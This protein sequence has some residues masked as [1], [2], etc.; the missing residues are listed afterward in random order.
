MPQRSLSIHEK[1]ALGK[2]DAAS[3]LLYSHPSVRVYTFQPPTDALKTLDRTKKTLPDADYPI[4][5]IEL[6]PW[7]SRTETLSAHGKLIIEKVQGSV[8]FLKCGGVIHTIMRNS[9]CWCVDGEA[10]FVLRV[11][12]LKYQRLEFPAAEPEE[13]GKVA[14]FKEVV[15]KILKFEKTPCPFIRAFQVDLPDDAITPRRR[16]TWKR[17]ESS[18]A[19][20]DTDSPTVR[21]KNTRTMSMRG[22]PPSAFPSRSMTY[23][24]ADRPRTASTPTVHG[25]FSFPDVRTESPTNYNSGED[26]TDSERHESGSEHP[27]SS[28]HSE[29][30][31]SDK[32]TH[33]VPI[34]RS[35]LNR[36]QRVS[37]DQESP[38]LRRSPEAKPRPSAMGPRRSSGVGDHIKLFESYKDE[39]RGSKARDSA[40]SPATPQKAP[41]NSSSTAE[42]AHPVE[43]VRTKARLEP[44]Q[45]RSELQKQQTQDVSPKETVQVEDEQRVE[46][47]EAY[48]TEDELFHRLKHEIQN[49]DE[50]EDELYQRLQIE[51]RNGIKHHPLRPEI[52]GIHSQEQTDKHDRDVTIGP[53]HAPNGDDSATRSQSLAPILTDTN[54]ALHPA[55]EPAS[56]GHQ[57][58]PAELHKVELQQP[59]DVIPEDIELHVTGPGKPH[60]ASTIE[61]AEINPNIEL[62]ENLQKSHTND[63][64][65]SIMSTDSFH[66]LLSDDESEPLNAYPEGLLQTRPFSHRRELSE[67]TVTAATMAYE[68]SLSPKDELPEPDMSGTPGAFGDTTELRQRLRHRRSLSPLPPAS[69][70]RSQSPSRQRSPIP[71][72][73]LQKAANLAVVKPIEVVMFVMHVLA[74]IAGG[75]TMNDL[76]S[77]ALF[78]RPGGPR[79]TAS[80]TFEQ[81]I[82]SK[83]K[84]NISSDS[85]DEDNEEDDYGMPVRGRRRSSPVKASIVSGSRAKR[86]DDAASL[87][88]VD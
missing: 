20:P 1:A 15:S 19:T 64:V 45:V 28:Q 33:K 56:G 14:E 21:T 85:I 2:D 16:G 68:R 36:M 76:T 48:E 9:Q 42:V 43:L 55:S 62:D 6:L 22:M 87:E 29:A 86:E 24:D 27:E 8:Q 46:H 84:A 37:S 66:T 79:R 58:G 61:L 73:L 54:Q 11:G 12:R 60:L 65:E 17:K 53:L 75:A 67:M 44:N 3:D 72:I 35:P 32:E 77:G 31:D 70:L 39:L 10:R 26:N 83:N 63:D 57:P 40:S 13:K 78:R 25:R 38:T 23:L 71:K 5:A 34:I 7:R 41:L 69:T 81:T 30:E 80:G 74:R 47:A 18:P 51:I 88:G 50:T 59:E 49:S 52:N 82:R 4:D